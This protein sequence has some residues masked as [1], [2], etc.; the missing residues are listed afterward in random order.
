M[1][2]DSKES[3]GEFDGQIF[4]DVEAFA[5]ILLRNV[6][7]VFNY[8]WTVVGDLG[9]CGYLAAF[10]VIGLLFLSGALALGGGVHLAKFDGLLN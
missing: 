6:A 9:Q 5:A 3:I 1:Q 4:G 7:F 10:F 8:A 2:L